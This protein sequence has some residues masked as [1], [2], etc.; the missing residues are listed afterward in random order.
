MALTRS[1][2][3]KA[4]DMDLPEFLQTDESGLI[5]LTGHRIGLEDVVHF[6]NE[7]SSPEMI[8]GQFPTVPLPLIY[9]VIAFYLENRK[10]WPQS[11]DTAPLRPVVQ[12]WMNCGGDCRRCTTRK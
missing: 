7:G 1:K 11:T 5:R 9:K 6:F 3:V 2:R 12:I 4:A 10:N 8:V